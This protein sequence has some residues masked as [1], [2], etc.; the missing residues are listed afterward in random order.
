MMRGA[1]R[2]TVQQAFTQPLLALNPPGRRPSSRFSELATFAAKASWLG[3]R[4]LVRARIRYAGSAGTSIESPPS[5]V[6]SYCLLKE[7]AG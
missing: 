5:A 2:T 6:T 7:N 4:F 3:A 1:P